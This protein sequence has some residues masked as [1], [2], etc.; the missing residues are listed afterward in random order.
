[1]DGRMRPG[2]EAS[3]PS[4]FDRAV[5]GRGGEHDR[6][7]RRGPGTAGVDLVAIE[8]RGLVV[9]VKAERDVE[10]RLFCESAGVRD[11]LGAAR[12]AVIAIEIDAVGVF[13]G[14]LDGC[15]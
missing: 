13:A 15:A 8:A 9:L 12:V 14:A 4:I 11:D 1:M 7:E 3:R 6:R 10:A 2:P 5:R